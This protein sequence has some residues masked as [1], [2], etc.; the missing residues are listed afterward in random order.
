MKAERWKQ[1]EKL[2]DAALELEAPR[3]ATFLDQACADDEDLRREVASLLASD[4]EAGSFLAAPAVE[5]AAKG[6]AAAEATSLIGRRIGHYQVLSLLGAG[7][8][9]EVYL[10]RDTR[11]NRQVAI[12]FLPALFAQHPDRLRRFE[13]EARATSALNHP[14]ILTIFDTGLHEGAPYLVA[15]LL[16]G[17]ELRA[18]LEQGPLPVRKALD[19]AQQIAQGLAAAHEKGIVHRDLKPENLFITTD[20][21]VKILDF[22]LA[23]L[24]TSIEGPVDSQ[25]ATQKPLTEPGTVM[26]TVG[27]MAPE[28][29]RGQD[30]DHRAD[31]FAFG[32]IL[33]EMLS[34][35]RPFSGASSVEVM[36]AILK[37]DPPEL[38]ET[39]AKIGPQLEKIVRR[40]LE[41]R[42]ERRFQSASDLGFAL[43]ALS[44]PSG[45]RLETAAVAPAAEPVNA[46]PRRSGREK[47]W[48]GATALAVLMAA[49]F[50]W[51]YFT[52]RP[53]ADARPMKLSLLPPEK[54]S[55]GH[56]AVSPDGRWLA[57]TAATG[58]KVQLWARALASADAKPF[59][60]TEG[61]TYPF[62]SPDSRFIGFFAGS[63]LK[64]VEASGGLPATLCDVGIGSGGT[65]NREGEILFSSVGGRA[66]QRVPAAG[67]AP[68]VVLRGDSQGQGIHAPSFLPDGRHFLCF[69]TSSEKEKIGVYLGSLDGKVWRRLQS[70]D[71][72]AI[73]A[74]STNRGRTSGT[75]GGYLLFGR[76]A[77]LMAQPFDAETLQLG[78]EPFP[79]AERVAALLGAATSYLHR[80][81]SVSENGVL[82]FDALPI[83]QR[84]QV[85][86]VDRG[87]S[88][89]S[90]P[91]GLENASTLR[92]APDDRRFAVARLSQQSNNNDLWLSDVTGGNA[93]RFTFYL[94]NDNYPIWSPDG[95][96][97]VWASNR[98][99]TFHLYEKAASGTGQDKLLLQSDY[100]TFP[101]DWARDG[102]YI[103]YRQIGPETKYDVWVLPLFGER[104]PFPFLRTEANEDTAVLSPDGQWMAYSSDESGRY[105]VYVQSFPGGGGK[106]QIST[107]GGIGPHWR[108]DGKELY[109]RAPD[110][111]LMA[112]PVIDTTSLAVGAPATLFEFRASG[113]LIAPYY[114]VSRDGQRFLLSTI[115]E[116][117]AAAPLTVVVNWTAESKQSP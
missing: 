44:A 97:I 16:E 95:S 66:I 1:I 102:R 98:I 13:L 94:G 41:K 5:V 65:W 19:Y 72:N 33:Y 100:P 103:I 52:L 4:E 7:G 20:G 76:E 105:E 32:V 55:F 110:G 22:G 61:A 71:S 45:H 26:G 89:I 62:W 107:A 8:M 39:N 113:N 29:V 36:N 90:S 111:K 25:V 108:V 85:F 112:V 10:A 50:A 42:P 82:V 59:E 49:G 3:R 54:T 117:D 114:S 88:K 63:K 93:V 80:N 43:E 115:V 18:Q 48:M 116:T 34:G 47:W 73:Y 38:G 60:G 14:N 78:G 87:G 92:L 77:A 27:Y 68:V 91:E 67:G 81:F 46:A 40:C 31:I 75:S 57:F 23:K 56:I 15:E 79:V 106:R 6:L 64:K 2:Y 101:S 104:K 53:V 69:A 58:S 96:R 51:A 28:Q 99:G 37:E 35:R 17:E 84:S 70:D 86:W 83:R 24:K 12:K 11:L 109:F 9:G 21:R 30:A 74:A